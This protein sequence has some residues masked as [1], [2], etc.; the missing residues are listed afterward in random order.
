MPVQIVDGIGDI[1]IKLMSTRLFQT[2]T[3]SI[4]KWSISTSRASEK[5]LGF[6]NSLKMIA[7]SL[8]F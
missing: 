5:V 7:R 3:L 1:Y 8:Q 6:S 4:K 2:H